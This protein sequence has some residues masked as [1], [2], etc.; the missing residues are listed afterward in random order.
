[1]YLGEDVV[2]VFN[3]HVFVVKLPRYHFDIKRIRFYGAVLST[4]A[5]WGNVPEYDAFN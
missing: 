5:V 2:L 4:R 1:M 3:K